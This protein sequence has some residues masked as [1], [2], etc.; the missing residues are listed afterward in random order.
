VELKKTVLLY[1]FSIPDQLSSSFL[2]GEG[3]KWSKLK[4]NRFNFQ[5]CT[6]F[7]SRSGQGVQ[8]YVIKLSVTCDMSVVFLCI[9]VSSTNKPDCHDIT[10]I[11]LKVALSTIN[12]N[13]TIKLRGWQIKEGQLNEGIMRQAS[14]ITFVRDKWKRLLDK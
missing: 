10:E 4:R 2:W 8:H 3:S 11:L 5:H 7:K 13:Q 14:T 1:I 12:P 6:E 9:P